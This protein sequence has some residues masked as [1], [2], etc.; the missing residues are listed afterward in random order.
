[1][2]LHTIKSYNHSSCLFAGIKKLVSEHTESLFQNTLKRL[3][4]MMHKSHGRETADQDV[5]MKVIWFFTEVN[6]S[7]VHC[8]GDLKYLLREEEKLTFCCCSCDGDLKTDHAMHAILTTTTKGDEEEEEE[9]SSYT[10]H[11]EEE[12]QPSLLHRTDDSSSACPRTKPDSPFSSLDLLHPPAQSSQHHLPSLAPSFQNSIALEKRSVS[13]ISV[14]FFFFFLLLFF[15][16]FSS[17]SYSFF[18]PLL[19]SFSHSPSPLPQNSRIS[20]K[21]IHSAIMSS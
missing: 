13:I 14:F 21:Q 18:I 2:Q 7:G 20:T 17:C 15:F 6:L 10:D 5:Q 8:D 19:F 11:E 12:E 4:C 3:D 9:P 16:F 1:M